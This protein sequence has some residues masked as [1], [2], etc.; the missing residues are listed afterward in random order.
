M[1]KVDTEDAI[2]RAERLD[3]DLQNAI[4]RWQTKCGSLQRHL[5]NVHSEAKEKLMGKLV[6]DHLTSITDKN[7][8]I[9]ELKRQ[10]QQVQSKLVGRVNDEEIQKKS[11]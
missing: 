11:D 8:Q 6:E 4:L 7:K 2:R 5:K 10:H 3:K 9:V 1:L